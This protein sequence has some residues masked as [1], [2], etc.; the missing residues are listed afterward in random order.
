MLLHF[1]VEQAL[2]MCWQLTEVPLVP[3]KQGREL[4]VALVQKMQVALVQQ[5]QVAMVVQRK[6]AAVVLGRLQPEQPP[7]LPV[8][9][10]SIEEAGQV[11]DPS[12]Q[13][14]LQQKLEPNWH[15]G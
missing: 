6:M 10:G 7:A 2:R 3:G 14:K 5:M 11:E 9:P 8:G 15:S 13:G 4:K 1:Q 12:V